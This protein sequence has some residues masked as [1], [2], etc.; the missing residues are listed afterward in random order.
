[1]PLPRLN[2]VVF[3]DITLHIIITLIQDMDR[4]VHDENNDTHENKAPEQRYPDLTTPPGLAQAQQ[5][6]RLEEAH[7]LGHGVNVAVR[8]DKAQ[9]C[10]WRGR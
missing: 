8:W 7:L 3:D 2:P 10:I 9:A 5:G 1:M 6:R 4:K